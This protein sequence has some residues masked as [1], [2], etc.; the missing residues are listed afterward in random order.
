MVV[1]T[2]WRMR[3]AKVSKS[4]G[5]HMEQSDQDRLF[6]IETT[7]Y[8]TVDDKPDDSSLERKLKHV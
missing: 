8:I 5:I 6:A 3:I 7:K 4:L 2:L 1:R